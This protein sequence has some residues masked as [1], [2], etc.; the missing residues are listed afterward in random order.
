M[1]LNDGRTPKQLINMELLKEAKDY[2]E[3]AKEMNVESTLET[4]ERNLDFCNFYL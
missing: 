4:I 3:K 1:A 2:L